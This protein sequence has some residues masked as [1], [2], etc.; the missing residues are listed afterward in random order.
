MK[1]H[2]ESSPSKF[3]PERA[4]DRLQFLARHFACIRSNRF[5]ASLRIP[6]NPSNRKLLRAMRTA[7]FEAWQKARAGDGH[8]RRHP[9]RNSARESGSR[10]LFVIR[11]DQ[12]G[13]WESGAFA[14]LAA[15]S[16]LAMLQGFSGTK[17]LLEGWFAFVQFVT[18]AVT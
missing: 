7:E 9:A 10:K 18:Q 6:V 13:L 11:D 16:V 2:A 14:V 8:L 3:V 1:T 15:S 4:V 12:T 17:H 5:T